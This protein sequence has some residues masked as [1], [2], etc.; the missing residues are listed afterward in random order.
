MSS[1]HPTFQLEEALAACRRQTSQGM[2][3]EA[4][5]AFPDEE[6]YLNAN[7]ASEVERKAASVSKTESG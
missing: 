7:N 3:E 5:Q 1:H 2:G 4:Y 6:A